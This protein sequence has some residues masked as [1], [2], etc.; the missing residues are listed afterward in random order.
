MA[1]IVGPTAVGKTKLSLHLA[2][3]FDGEI[4]SG[5]SMQV[6]RGMD[7]G[8]AKATAEERRQI[9]HHMIDIRN[10]DEPFS[11]S[12]FQ[13]LASETIAD[14][15]RRGKL[16][17]LVGGTGL[18]VESVCYHFEFSEKGSDV[19]LRETLWQRAEREGAEALHVELT[20]VD[21]VSASRIHPNDARRTIR[22]LEVYLQTGTRLSETRNRR[23][24]DYDLVWIGLNMD[25]ALLYRRIEERI[26]LM[27]EEGLVEEVRELRRRGYDEQQVSMQALGYK[28]ILAY[29]KGECGYGQAVELLKRDTRRFAKRQLSWFRRLPQIH[30]FDLTD[31]K[32]NAEQFDAI[33]DII[34]GKFD[35]RGEYN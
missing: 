16:P 26:D 2:E 32:K 19:Q 13:Q 20:S 29:L 24:S 25:R 31:P 3:R 4:V 1:V 9:P 22:A 12:D 14:I 11:V 18:Y 10:P 7:I 27:L 33:S 5:D 23:E 28:E 21:P 35:S 34:A 15:H 30:W 6:Y 8:T 17:L